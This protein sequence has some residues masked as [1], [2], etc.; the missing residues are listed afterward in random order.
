MPKTKENTALWPDDTI[1]GAFIFMVNWRNI[2]V[3]IG[4]ISWWNVND[5][6]EQ[7]DGNHLMNNVRCRTGLSSCFWTKHAKTCTVYYHPEMPGRSIEGKSG[8]GPRLPWKQD[9]REGNTHKH[10]A[11]HTH[12]IS[13]GQAE[14]KV[15]T[16]DCWLMAGS[17]PLPNSDGRSRPLHLLTVGLTDPLC[18]HTTGKVILLLQQHKHESTMGRI[19]AKR[20]AKKHVTEIWQLYGFLK[21]I[22]GVSSFAFFK[23]RLS[24]LSSTGYCIPFFLSSLIWV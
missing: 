4:K 11:T 8:V 21:V 9:Y 12:R 23:F 7:N 24:Q 5:W 14:V 20:W 17:V 13:S 22:A 19:K 15:P 2:C 10:R 1:S 6:C 3:N 18:R 16:W